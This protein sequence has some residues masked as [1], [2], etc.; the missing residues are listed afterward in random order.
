MAKQERR[1]S[2]FGAKFTVEIFDA[3][4]RAFQDPEEKD[5][6]SYSYEFDCLNLAELVVQARKSKPAMD[7]YF[8]RIGTTLFRTAK[9]YVADHPYL[10][11]SEVYAKIEKTAY[12]AVSVFDPAKGNF[13]HLF[14]R[15]LKIS[16]LYY[17]KTQAMLHQRS[18][19]H[20]GQQVRDDQYLA[21]FCDSD[22]SLALDSPAEEI[23]RGI[24][25]DSFREVLTP[26]EKK[27]LDYYLKDYTIENI[28][29]LLHLPPSTVSY[30]LYLLLDE[31]RQRYQRKLI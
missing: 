8:R 16:L 26:Q 20:F 1:H 29:G 22:A 3:L 30:R 18:L 14:R 7:E 12:E 11:F 4:E 6:P 31:L 15:M 13:L 2:S 5:F 27:I 28:A 24:D 9:S 23:A 17:S 10:D 25:L 21:A 19:D